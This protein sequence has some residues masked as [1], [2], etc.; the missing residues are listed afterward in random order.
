MEEIILK[1]QNEFDEEIIKLKSF[2][3]L[4]NFDIKFFG[5]K[6]GLLTDLMKGVANLSPDE[7]RMVGAKLNEF[8][9]EL[10]HRFEEKKKEITENI[11]KENLEK[12]SIDI[13]M[14]F[15]GWQKKGTL[16]PI[17]NA[18]R[19]LE[20]VCL[21][22]GFR[23]EDGPEM[24]SD[25]YV[26]EALNIPENHPARDAQDT[27]YVKDFGEV[28]MRSHVSN[29]QVRMLEKYGVPLKI[30]YPGRVFRNEALDQTHSH[31]FYQF[32]ALIVDKNI[33]IANLVAVIKE[34]LSALFKREI[35]VRLRPGHFPFVEPGF[36]MDM[37]IDFG[38]GEKWVEM[39]GCGL[40]H[41]HVLKEAGL[42][43][44]VYQGLAFGMG[45][46]RLVMAKYG[47]E[48]VRHLLGGNL[49]FL[50]QFN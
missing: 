6:N 40:V 30:A 35:K 11:R 29:M 17:T 7:K 13:T 8:K 20:E 36:E 25:Y 41:S 28:C 49:E 45:L 38:K 47:I 12:E 19:E 46:D 31:T 44:N 15:L 43:P 37:L 26:F 34:L 24:E 21:Q 10:E 50:E 22:M 42:D 9:K 33:S 39:L 23:V 27:F 18:M 14:P 5:R 1:I 16:H 48:D 3:D 2:V 4:E 32:E